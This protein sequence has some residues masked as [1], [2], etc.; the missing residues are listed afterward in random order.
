MIIEAIKI[1]MIAAVAIVC[2]PLVLILFP[3][4]A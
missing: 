3:M 4:A 1:V 2:L